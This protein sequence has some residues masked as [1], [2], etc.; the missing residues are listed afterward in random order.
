MATR[1][2]TAF[3]EQATIQNV[4]E[5]SKLEDSEQEDSEQE[6]DSFEEDPNEETTG[7]QSIN[8]N[9]KHRQS[10][11]DPRWSRRYPWVKYVE[12][13]GLYCSWCQK[14][15]ISARNKQGVWTDK[16]CLSCR[17]DK[18][19]AHALTGSHKQAAQLEVE[20]EEE[21][22]HGGIVKAFEKTVSIERKA[23]VS[24]LKIMHWLAKEELPHTTKF[25]SLIKLVIDLGGQQLKALNKGNNAKYT[26][27]RTIQEMIQVLSDTAL[28]EV[29]AEVHASPFVVLLC[30]ESTDVLV[31]KQLVVYVKYITLNGDTRI[32][33]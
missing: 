32:R 18:L 14:H 1:R 19:Q 26:S 25:E 10:G 12:G 30:D 8:R 7:E 22:R 27:E 4:E 6:Q 33:F 16:P 20:A 23:F 9:A 15:K 17:K 11:F 24:A 13:K 21:A 29:L 2:I 3:F 31:T 5:D 28:E